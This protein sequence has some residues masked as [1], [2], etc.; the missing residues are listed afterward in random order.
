MS[1][2]PCATCGQP[3]ERVDADPY[4]SRHC[5]VC[6]LKRTHALRS[7]SQG[8]YA[9]A[10]AALATTGFAVFPVT[11]LLIAANAL[12]YMLMIFSGASAF[13]PNARDALAFGADY[14]PLTLNGEWWRV[15]TSTFVHF[16]ALHIGLNMWCLWNL[17]RATERLMGRFSYLLAYFASGIFGSISSLYWHPRVVG[18]GASGAIFGLAGALLAF[19]YLKKTPAHL[20]V[21]RNMLGSLGTFVLFNLL[22]GAAP[23]IDN[24]AHL[25]GLVMGLLVGA[26][27]PSAAADESS[28]RARLSLVTAVALLIVL[29]SAIATQRAYVSAPRPVPQSHRSTDNSPIVA[30]TSGLAASDLA[31][32]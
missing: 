3:F 24:T 12:V 27:L 32:V 1:L 15:V 7:A 31:L 19:V 9:T 29:V 16:G 21:N 6:D 18:A 8:P 23:G 10:G 28:R 20:S 26:V 22:Y 4:A 30:C 5:P 11:Y 14:G 25:G 13:S 17:G 2:Q